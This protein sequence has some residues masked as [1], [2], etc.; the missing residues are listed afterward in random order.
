VS[1]PPQFTLKCAEL[2][3]RQWIAIPV[4]SGARTVGDVLT[5]AT[6]H[7]GVA[8]ASRELIGALR[9]PSHA[10]SV[11]AAPPVTN[12]LYAISKP[13]APTATL[14]ASGLVEGSHLLLRI[15]SPS[16]KPVEAG[17]QRMMDALSSGQVAMQTHTYTRKRETRTVHFLEL[18]RLDGMPLAWPHTP[19]PRLMVRNFYAPLFNSVLGRLRPSPDQQFAVTGQ[20]GHAKSVFGWYCIWRA[21]QENPDRAIV[22]R[23]FK[24]SNATHVYRRELPSY[25]QLDTATSIPELAVMEALFVSDGA[26]SHLQNATCL[27]IASP[28]GFVGQAAKEW[29]KGPPEVKT[30]HWPAFTEPEVWD[31]HELAYQHLSEESVAARMRVWGPNPRL[32]LGNVSKSAQERALMHVMQTPPS[33]ILDTLRRGAHGPGDESVCDLLVA[34]TRGQVAGLDGIPIPMEAEAYYE[35]VYVDFASDAL[36]QWA[37]RYLDASRAFSA[38]SVEGVPLICRPIGQAAH[39]IHKELEALVLHATSLPP[40]PGGP[41]AMFVLKPT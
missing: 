8:G 13:L 2:L 7:L 12:R 36:R 22:Y 38:T 24:Y 16:A 29:F 41:A 1:D 15:P 28:H 4:P 19:S 6:V 37:I 27:S 35:P 23:A 30:F 21:L 33:T 18:P 9:V 20:P 17:F 26:P 34:R 39:H 11:G 31:L 10:V 32:V 3:S 40:S 5:C 25:R 14:A